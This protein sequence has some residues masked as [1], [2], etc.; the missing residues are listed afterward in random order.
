M[1]ETLQQIYQRYAD[2]YGDKQGEMVFTFSDKGAMHSYI[3]FYESYFAKKRDHAK[4]LEIG[5]MTGGSMLLWQ[6][7]F[8]RYQLTGIDL[9]P[10][11]NQARPFQPKLE[12]DDNIKLMFG[13]NSVKGVP[14]ELLAE[15][16]DF[17]IDD[18]DHA[19]TSQI[20]TFQNYYPL[21]SPGGTYF[22][23][24]IIGENELAALRKFILNYRETNYLD[25]TIRHH[26]GFKNGRRDDQILAITRT[27]K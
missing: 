20:E 5:M 21:L 18:G 24:D 22:I 25:F 17:I 6:T 1:K 11:W 27:V 3:D 12:S 26:A 4:L 16:F 13:I 23:E 2:E 14:D 7:Y 19:V 8:D 10:S 9:S 15:K